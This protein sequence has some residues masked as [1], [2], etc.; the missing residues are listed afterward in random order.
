MSLPD[1]LPPPLHQGAETLMV[2]RGPWEAEPP[3]DELRAATFP[4]LVVSGGW[5]P[6]FD[7]VCDVLEDRLDAERAV[8]PGMGHNPQLLG[9][10]F[11]DVLAVFLGR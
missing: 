6:A 11:N 3:L 4:K 9:Q 8:L 5:N 10:T 2:E 7:A 1:P